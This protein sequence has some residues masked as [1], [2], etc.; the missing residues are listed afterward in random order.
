MVTDGPESPTVVASFEAGVVHNCV[1]P[2]AR[3][4]DFVVVAVA[5]HAHEHEKFLVGEGGALVDDRFLLD[6]GG[7]SLPAVF[8]GLIYGYV[9]VAVGDDFDVECDPVAV[10]TSL[11]GDIALLVRRWDCL[12]KNR[13]NPVWLQLHAQHQLE[14]GEDQKRKQ[15]QQ[16]EEEEQ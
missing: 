16:D 13:Q 9:A 10:A 14:K 11:V 2:F 7:T 12:Q 1:A 3:G 6:V 8:V 5:E 15:N 4:N